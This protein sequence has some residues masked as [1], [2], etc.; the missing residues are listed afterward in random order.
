MWTSPQI[1]MKKF[2]WSS[3]FIQSGN[4]VDKNQLSHSYLTLDAHVI[5]VPCILKRIIIKK[6]VVDEKRLMYW[7]KTLLL[8][9]S[10]HDGKFL[11]YPT[12]HKQ[13]TSTRQALKERNANIPIHNLTSQE[14]TWQTQDNNWIEETVPSDNWQ[15]AYKFHKARPKYGQVND[16]Q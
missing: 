11:L 2:K 13:P 16:L 4:I 14:Q 5:V 8:L 10:Y 1:L 12:I 7:Q 9:T 6:R 15:Y 3:T